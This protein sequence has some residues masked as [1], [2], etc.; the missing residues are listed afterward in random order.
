MRILSFF[1]EVDELKC[2]WCGELLQ[3]PAYVK[4]V[5][6]SKYNFCSTHCKKSFRKAGLGKAKSSCSACALSK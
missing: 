4:Y 3:S 1:K 2:D 6:A 5:G